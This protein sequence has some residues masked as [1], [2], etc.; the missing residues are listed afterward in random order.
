MLIN[1]KKDLARAYKEPYA[2][3]GGYPVYL[4]LRDGA[5]LCRKCFKGEYRSI[6]WDL[7]NECNTGWDLMA[8]KHYTRVQSIAAIVARN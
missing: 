4:L 1:D 6:V 2:W 8:W 3:P 5:L 7:D